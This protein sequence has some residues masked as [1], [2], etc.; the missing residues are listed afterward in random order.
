[1]MF[2]G[3]YV[4][5]SK[6]VPEILSDAAALDTNEDKVEF[7]RLCD[8]NGLRFIASAM[9]EMD[10][11][12]VK[13]PEYTRSTYPIGNCSLSISNSVN[14]LRA[15]H[16]LKDTQPRRSQ[17]LLLLVLENVH[18][19]EAQLIERVIK[20]GKVEGVSKAVFRKVYPDM[21]RSNEKD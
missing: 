8:N 5:R 7:L 11:R 21:F 15:A 9:Y 6:T 18:A 3:R 17:H 16:A 20:G 12:G 19:N 13:I 1:M 2:K 14:R 4:N 10:W